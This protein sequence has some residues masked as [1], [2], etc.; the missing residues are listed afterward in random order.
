MTRE[1]AAAH[2]VSETDLAAGE[3]LR[4]AHILL[5]QLR[6]TFRAL[7]SSRD[8]APADLIIALAGALSAILP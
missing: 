4:A 3:R 6:E 8:P 7:E 5:D 1:L 2:D